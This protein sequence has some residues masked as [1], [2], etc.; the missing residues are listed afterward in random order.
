LEWVNQNKKIKEPRVIGA[1]IDLGNCFNLVESQYNELLKEGYEI[2]KKNYEDAELELPINTG[3]DEDKKARNLD[4]AVIQQVHV[5]V[6]ELGL[7]PFDSVRGVFLEGPEVYP[8][9]GFKERTHMQICVVN[10]NCIKG[11]FD[12][13]SSDDN[14]QIP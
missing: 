12:P 8:G 1:V 2:L 7:T 3:R 6:E 10:P 5:L 9:A 11:Y 4:C 14:H 13:L